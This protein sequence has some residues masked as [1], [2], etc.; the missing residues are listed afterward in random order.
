MIKAV[1][2][3]AVVFLCAQG[4]DALVARDTIRAGEPLTH[5]NTDASDGSSDLIGREVKRT[6]YAGQEILATNTRAARLVQRNQTV[7]VRY[8]SDGLQIAVT[9][10]AMGEAGAGEAVEAMN[11]GSRKII[12]GIVTPEGW[13]LAQ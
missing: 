7:E 4:A 8:V 1:F 2:S 12:S 11:I 3:S 9:A 5:E 6:I 10:R 13:I